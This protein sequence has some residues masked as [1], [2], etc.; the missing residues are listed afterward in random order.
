MKSVVVFLAE[1]FEEIEAITMV[2]VLRR[3]SI[4]CDTCSIVEDKYYVTGAHGIEIK[5]DKNINDI[6]SKEYDCL[7]L[8]GG[9]PGSENLKQNNVVIKMINEFN[10]ENKIIGA[11]CAAPIVLEEAGIL[12]NKK[13]TSYPGFEKMLGDCNYIEDIVVEDGNIV[14][15]RGPATALQFSLKIVEKLIGIEKSNELKDEMMLD[16]VMNKI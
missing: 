4:E 1:G 3:V 6:N 13:V 16:F 8:P 10:K 15:S 14:T 7:I 9:M 5:A 11:I 2:D 12:S